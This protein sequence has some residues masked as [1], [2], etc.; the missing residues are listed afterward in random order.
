MKSLS[1]FKQEPTV[2]LEEEKTDYSKFDMLVRAG[3]ANKA[4]IQRLHVILD[5]MQEERPV[6]S[7]ADRA[8]MQNLFNKMVD[9]ISNNK[10]L[11]QQTRRLVREELEEGVKDTSNFKVVTDAAGNQ[12]K[13]KAHRVVINPDTV[14]ADKEQ[15]KEETLDENVLQ[16]DPPAVLVLRRKNI[17]SFSN[18]TY[19][20]L[21]YNDKLNKYFSIPYST[22]SDINSPIQAEEVQIDEAKIN[23]IDQ[24]KKIRDSKQHGTVN[25]LDG[26]ASKVDGF[27]A[28]AILQVHDKLNDENKKKIANMVS[29]SHYHLSK[30]ANFAFSKSK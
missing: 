15:M 22:N 27:T 2:I 5:K 12:R 29:S 7:N 21:Y 14:V 3:L 26:S 6:F 19:I 4:Q 17:R 10:Q 13:V 8:I 30:V 11:F 23:G 18:D 1:K 25:H 20:A 16:R 9:L 28:S 24:L